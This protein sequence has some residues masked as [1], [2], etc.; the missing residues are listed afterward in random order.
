MPT[1]KNEDYKISAVKHYLDTNKTQKNICNIFKCSEESE[2]FLSR[3]LGVAQCCSFD[4]EVIKSRTK[5]KI[6]DF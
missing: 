5:L 4:D 2:T 1:H 3:T 6:R